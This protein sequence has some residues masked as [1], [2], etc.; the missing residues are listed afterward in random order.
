MCCIIKCV[1]NEN[2]IDIKMSLPCFNYSKGFFNVK[3]VSAPTF[4]PPNKKDIAYRMEQIQEKSTDKPTV[5][6]SLKKCKIVKKL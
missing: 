5:K 1:L 4:P 2:V 3:I 6:S